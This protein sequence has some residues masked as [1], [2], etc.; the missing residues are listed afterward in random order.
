[1]ADS[2]SGGYDYNYDCDYDS[3]DEGLQMMLGGM[4]LGDISCDSWTHQDDSLPTRSTS[5]V[6]NNG[7]E[8]SQKHGVTIDL[9]E[10]QL[11]DRNLGFSSRV[12]SIAKDGQI[13]PPNVQVVD[14]VS[15]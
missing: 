14:L 7:N 12:H 4:A 1:M 10:I 15:L 5:P 9:K 11:S 13:V 6:R 2:S 8:W 3:A